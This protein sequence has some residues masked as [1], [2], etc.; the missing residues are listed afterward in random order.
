M[1][2]CEPL[3]YWELMSGQSWACLPRSPAFSGPSLNSAQHRCR[4]PR[5][6]LTH[7]GRRY[8]LPGRHEPGRAA[9]HRGK[10]R[11]VCLS[12]HASRGPSRH[13]RVCS[14]S[15]EPMR[16]AVPQDRRPGRRRPSITASRL[17]ELGMRPQDSWERE[18]PGLRCWIDTSAC[19]PR[20]PPHHSLHRYNYVVDGSRRGFQAWA[21]F[22][23]PLRVD[24]PVPGPNRRVPTPGSPTGSYSEATRA[25]RSLS[26]PC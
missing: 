13:R 24:C 18:K 20:R 2:G 15:S 7:E 1:G 4:W 21:L 10:D 16:V 12:R 25:A 8:I 19:N 3:R 23:R 9:G 6:G 22:G 11:L 17:R 26:Q 5:R 14:C